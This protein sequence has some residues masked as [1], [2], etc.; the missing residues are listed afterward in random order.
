MEAQRS[1]MR[2]DKWLWVAR[3]FKTRSRASEAVSGGKVRLNGQRVKPAKLVFSGD[4]LKIQRDPYTFEIEIAGLA[5]QR[6][7]ACLAVALY[8]ETS[9]SIEQRKLMREQLKHLRVPASPGRPNKKQRRELQ[10]L[11]RSMG[12][13]HPRNEADKAW[14]P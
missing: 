12:D 2:L 1:S 6:L 10:R 14:E 5:A 4:C 11:Q 9:Q 3:F 8:E 13:K 7:P